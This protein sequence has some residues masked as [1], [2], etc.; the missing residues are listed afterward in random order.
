MNFVKLIQFTTLYTGEFLNA[1]KQ[2]LGRGLLD[3]PDRAGLQ[4]PLSDMLAVAALK[5]D[6]SPTASECRGFLHLYHAGFLVM[7]PEFDLIGILEAASMPNI[8]SPTVKRGLAI[9]VVTGTLE[10]WK[11]AIIR[12]ASRSSELEIRQTYNNVYLE[13][14]RIGVSQAFDLKSVDTQDSTVYLEQK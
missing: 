9:A 7:A 1:T 4:S 12:G 11:S 14:T 6:V 13:F 2:A 10:Q 8:T 5:G 3:A